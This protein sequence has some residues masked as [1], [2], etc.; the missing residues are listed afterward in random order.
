MEEET[1]KSDVRNGLRNDIPLLQSMLAKLSLKHKHPISH[2]DTAC[3]SVFYHSLESEEHITN[4]EDRKDSTVRSDGDEEQPT[5]SSETEDGKEVVEEVKELPDA[6]PNWE[7]KRF[8]PVSLSKETQASELSQQPSKS[9]FLEDKKNKET[10][11]EEHVA[12]AALLPNNPSPETSAHTSYLSVSSDKV[13]SAQAGFKHE[14][15]DEA[16]G[17]PSN[18]V[19][20]DTSRVLTHQTAV[21]LTSKTTRSASDPVQHK[22]KEERPLSAPSISNLWEYEDIA[23]AMSMKSFH[24]A[25]MILGQEDSG[26]S[27]GDAEHDIPLTK[28]QKKGVKNKMK[29]LTQKLMEKLKDKH[30]CE[31]TSSKSIQGSV[32]EEGLN[33]E[34]E[35]PEIPPPLP[36]KKGKYVFLDRRFTLKDFKLN[37][38]PINLMEE[39]FTGSEWLSYLPSKESPTEKDTSDQSM[40]NYVLQPE[41]DIQLNVPL[42]TPEQDQSEDIKDNQDI[43]SD[44]QEDNVAKANSDLNVKQVEQDANI[45]AIPKAL[46]TSNAIKQRAGIDCETKKS[47]DIYDRVDMYII[48]RNDFPLMQRKTSD[49]PLDFSAVKSFELLD[50]SALKSRIRLSKKRHHRPPKKHKK[51]KT[52]TSSAIFY[53]IPPVI[54]NESPVSASQ[55]RHSIPFS[56]SPPLHLPSHPYHS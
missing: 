47:E 41:K 7:R 15:P 14:P 32:E 17:G 19:S 2:P 46:L 49:A 21:N 31:H 6:L 52:E 51:V 1:A 55:P 5:R 8:L 43:V 35:A 33:M 53:K 12:G 26:M 44:P 48:P 16:C 34:A 10:S 25:A 39:I 24:K 28:T 38:E 40:T 29:N 27:I 23:N 30:D 50:N 18:P 37:L 9:E 3:K 20:M 13:D 56:T 11:M 45:F 36:P 42:P 4:E 54:L 22:P